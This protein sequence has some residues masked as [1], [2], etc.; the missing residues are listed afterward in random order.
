MGKQRDT[1]KLQ[2]WMRHG[3]SLDPRGQDSQ[4]E[5]LIMIAARQLQPAGHDVSIEL[6][7]YLGRSLCHM[8]RPRSGWSGR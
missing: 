3:D 1:R 5:S 8:R 7:V 2:P 6:K 4:V